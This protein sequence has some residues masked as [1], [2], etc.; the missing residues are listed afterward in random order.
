MR[1]KPPRWTRR[2]GP[3][4]SVGA[5]TSSSPEAPGGREK[6]SLMKVSRHERDGAW[7]APRN[8]STEAQ[9]AT[10]TIAARAGLIR[11]IVARG[12]APTLLQPGD[13]SV[14]KSRTYRRISRMRRK[15]NNDIWPSKERI[16]STWQTNISREYS[17]TAQRISTQDRND[18]ELLAV[19]T[20]EHD[21]NAK[22][23]S[24][25]RL[26]CFCSVRPCGR[27]RRRAWATTSVG[28]LHEKAQLDAVKTKGAHC[29]GRQ[30]HCQPD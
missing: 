22:T 8:S 4:N 30:V 5:C 28:P 11:I 17:G 15:S 18:C 7:A 21:E 1:L 27:A 25:V 14:S 26:V 6:Y 16:L 20:R 2:R 9:I 3:W 23:L 12:G 24:R 13:V 29:P 10:A 19:Q